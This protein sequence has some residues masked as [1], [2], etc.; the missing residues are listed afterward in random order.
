[1]FSSC[2]TVLSKFSFSL[3]GCDVKGRMDIRC[4]LPQ[5]EKP[6]NKA[7]SDHLNIKLTYSSTFYLIQ[8]LEVSPFKYIKWHFDCELG[9]WEAGLVIELAPW[10]WCLLSSSFNSALRSIKLW[11]KNSQSKVPLHVS[12]SADMHMRYK[13]HLFSTTTK[14]TTHQVFPSIEF[15][16]TSCKQSTLCN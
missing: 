9:V 14:H 7:A 5:L 2:R 8:N 16:R 3:S 15:W 10:L 4:T 6:C 11:L 12:I 1:M 13:L